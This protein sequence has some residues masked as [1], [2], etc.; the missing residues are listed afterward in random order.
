VVF[1]LPDHPAK[2]KIFTRRFYLNG[3]RPH[4]LS[5]RAPTRAAGTGGAA[6]TVLAEGDAAPERGLEVE[7]EDAE[8]PAAAAG[9]AELEHLVEVAVVDAP[10]VAHADQA[11]AHDALRRRGIERREELLHV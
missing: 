9:G 10:V 8:R 3:D 11:A 6:E 5:R 1:P 2:P 7:V 4:F